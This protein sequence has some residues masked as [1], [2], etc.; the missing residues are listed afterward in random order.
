MHYHH[1]LKLS[2]VD[3]IDHF[4]LILCF[5]WI[6]LAS[7]IQNMAAT[8]SDPEKDVMSTTARSVIPSWTSAAPGN[9]N[10]NDVTRHTP[11]QVFQVLVGIHTPPPLTQ[12]G[13]D[14]ARATDTCSRRGRTDN[15]GLYQ[16]AKERERS[17]RIAYLC[18]SYIS[19]ILYIL[20]ILLAATFTSLSA[21]KDAKPVALTVLGA[22]NTV[23]AGYVNRCSWGI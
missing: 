21:Y 20:Q 5:S 4:S 7:N 17:A 23:L 11:L 8:T 12:D 19:N 15:I 2:S 22:L 1:A 16:R 3:E 10:F 6:L 13:V 14:V 9:T 18:T